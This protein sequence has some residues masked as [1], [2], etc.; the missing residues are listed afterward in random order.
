MGGFGEEVMVSM[1]TAETLFVLDSGTVG[2]T[3]LSLLLQ[4]TILDVI[5]G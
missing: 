3:R 2:G 5:G 1:A 4:E